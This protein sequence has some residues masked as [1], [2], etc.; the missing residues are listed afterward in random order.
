M[1][2]TTQNSYN[3]PFLQ[4]FFAYLFRWGYFAEAIRRKSPWLLGLFSSFIAWVPLL[5]II[6]KWGIDEIP[7]PSWWGT[8]KPYI[9][10]STLIK[11]GLSAGISTIFAAVFVRGL[12]PL[13]FYVPQSIAMRGLGL[14]YISGEHEE[15]W[16]QINKALDAHK[17]N[18][19][20]RVICI[21]GE[22]L[23]AKAVDPHGK[24]SPLHQAAQDGKLEVIM[25]VSLESNPTVS[26]RYSCL[27]SDYKKRNQIRT[28]EAYVRSIGQNKEFLRDFSNVYYEH[29]I[30]CMWR[31]ILFS[32]Q[33]VVQNYFPCP[34]GEHSYLAPT[35][36]FNKATEY[37][38][39]I[40]YYSTFSEMFDLI[41]KNCARLPP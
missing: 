5:Y 39:Q 7:N 23:F 9:Q 14:A 36:I 38:N 4:R 13:L 40:S 15:S 16:K 21:R 28:I 22:Y 1:P 10:C 3:A 20:I 25:P 32:D 12:F 18:E 26:N 33:C 17:S 24:I 11:F 8:L 37:P 30:L 34:P 6:K 35:F 19:K 29:N 27:S 31:V 2:A 41:K